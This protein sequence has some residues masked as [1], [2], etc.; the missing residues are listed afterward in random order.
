VLTDSKSFALCWLRQ[1][2]FGL[3]V[4]QTFSPQDWELQL[5]PLLLH[6]P[7]KDQQDKQKKMEVKNKPHLSFP[8]E[9]SNLIE[10]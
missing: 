8:S 4:L 3:D 5:H 2:S 10:F 6:A 9:L 7:E 1:V